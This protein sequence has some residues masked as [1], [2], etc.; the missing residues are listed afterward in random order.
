M[1]NVTVSNFWPCI[2][3]KI[4]F[5][6]EYKSFKHWLMIKLVFVTFT[7]IDILHADIWINSKLWTR[8]LKFIKRAN[9]RVKSKQRLIFDKMEQGWCCY[10]RSSDIPGWTVKYIAKQIVKIDHVVMNNINTVYSQSNRHYA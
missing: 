8:K 1:N 6:F 2:L 10:C 4:M 9:V 7:H 5:F 3:T